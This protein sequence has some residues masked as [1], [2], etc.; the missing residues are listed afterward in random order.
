[1][2]RTDNMGG[3]RV[4]GPS[5][6]RIRENAIAWL[7]TIA[8]LS[9]EAATALYDQQLLRDSE[10]FVQTNDDEIDSM[11]RAVRR[12]TGGDTGLIIA[13]KSVTRLKLTSFYVKHQARTSRTLTSLT[14]VTPDQI[15]SLRDQR[16][17]ELSWKDTHPTPDTFPATVLEQK[18]A[19]TTFEQIR[20]MLA[21]IRGVTGVPLAYVIRPDIEV[22]DSSDDPSYFRTGTKYASVDLELI[23]RAPILADGNSSDDDE[24]LEADGPFHPKFSIDNRTVWSILN[25]MFSG[26]GQWQ[27]CKKYSSSQNGQKVWR[28]LHNL[29]YGPE[30]I[31]QHVST[32]LK[33]LGELTYNEDTRNWNFDKYCQA[34]CEQHNVHAS[35]EEFGVAKLS[36]E[37]KIHHFE[38]GIV[39]PS[40]APVK[41]GMV[42]NQKSHTTFAQVMQVYVDFKAATKTAGP[43]PG[44]TV[45]SVDRSSAG[46]GGGGRGGRGN[47]RHDGR[48]RGG[49]GSDQ[50]RRPD[51]LPS[52]EEVDKCTHITESFYPKSEY[53]K[54]TPAEKQ[55]VYQNKTGRN[56]T[57]TARAVNQLGQ[58][59]ASAISTVVSEITAESPVR[60]TNNDDETWGHDRGTNR[61]NPN[62]DRDSLELDGRQ[63][64]KPRA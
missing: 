11:C 35:L 50:A 9:Q 62:L 49:R 14:S 20:S 56:L 22:V 5:P 43:T 48:K 52:Q 53:A 7:R 10:A 33:K 25:A 36:E 57:N 29:F 37:Q 18:T 21:R 51:K 8:L 15:L 40:L 3:L 19:A 1:M 31:T 44:R 45:S 34:H 27:Y 2:A 42:L 41:A 24:E 59:F 26:G 60:K 30:R 46:R 32:V 55:K 28:T 39:S 64:K 61:D 6:I 38:R 16:D 12:G 4:T 47:S 13:E 54:M 23:S 17:L 58:Q 63:S